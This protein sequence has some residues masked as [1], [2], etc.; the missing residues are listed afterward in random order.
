MVLC[1]SERHKWLPN[2][3]NDTK[4]DF[5]VTGAFFVKLRMDNRYGGGQDNRVFATPA[6]KCFLPEVQ[7]LWEGKLGR[8]L[9][10]INNVLSASGYA[11]PRNVLHN[12]EEWCNLELQKMFLVQDL[13]RGKW[14]DAGSRGFLSERVRTAPK[15][16][17][18]LVVQAVC[19]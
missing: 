13:I 1:K 7:F 15:G 2:L 5:F 19:R 16:P 11:N 3:S 9:S 4:P 18:T 14:T 12:L 10:V 8:M 17:L 6:D